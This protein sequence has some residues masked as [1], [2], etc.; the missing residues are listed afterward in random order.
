VPWHQS[1]VVGASLKGPLVPT[2]RLDATSPMDQIVSALN[3]F[4][5]GSLVAYAGMAKALALE[6]I[7]GR[8]RIAR[9][10]VMC[11]SEVLT[12]GARRV[13][14]QAFG[15][16]P[17]ET[18]AATETAG[19]ASDCRLRRLHLYEDLVVTEIVDDDH[20]PVPDGTC[21]SKLFVT[22]VFSRTIPLIRYELSDSVAASGPPC[23]C[24]LPFGTIEG[25][26]GRREDVLSF[27]GSTGPVRVQPGVLSDAIEG[28]AGVRAWQVVQESRRRIRVRIVASAD[29]DD[30]GLEDRPASF[31]HWSQPAPSSRRS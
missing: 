17:Y 7:E 11:A 2:L 3:D 21:G 16:E 24:G 13:I 25:V 12:A 1:A 9:R 23:G 28:D 4:R 30:R 19:I 15:T 20:L 10:S 22:V 5:P 26:R 31:P 14:R 18:Y 27:D 6:R 29:F 8:L